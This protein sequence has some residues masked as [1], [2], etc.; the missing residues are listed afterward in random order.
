MTTDLESVTK[1]PPFFRKC[2]T[3][4]SKAN[5][6]QTLSPKPSSMNNETSFPPPCVN[7]HKD[8]SAM[9]NKTS[10]IFKMD[11]TIFIIHTLVKQEIHW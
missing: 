1:A 5:N 6:R 8:T 4:K 2:I 9:I 7:N 11:N 10:T 3:K